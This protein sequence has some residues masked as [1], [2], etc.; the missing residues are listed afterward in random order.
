MFFV[1]CFNVFAFTLW[2][3]YWWGLGHTTANCLQETKECYL[4]FGIL[5]NLSCIFWETADAVF[6]TVLKSCSFLKEISTFLYKLSVVKLSV[7]LFYNLRDFYLYNISLSP[8]LSSLTLSPPQHLLKSSSCCSLLYTT[9]SP[10][11]FFE[12]LSVGHL[13]VYLCKW[14]SPVNHLTP[15]HT[16]QTSVRKPLFFFPLILL[17]PHSAEEETAESEKVNNYSRLHSKS[18]EALGWAGVQHVCS[19]PTAPQDLTVK[20]KDVHIL[21]V[22]FITRDITGGQDPRMAQS[23]HSWHWAT[24][25]SDLNI[26]ILTAIY[27]V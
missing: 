5:L 11:P 18:E 7:S 15:N 3:G 1:D 14:V 6:R 21:Y 10:G 26:F 16:K 22:L 13:S 2:A 27:D 4:L 8:A 12:S 17:S 25:L 9:Q 23:S 19:F 24:P 20:Y